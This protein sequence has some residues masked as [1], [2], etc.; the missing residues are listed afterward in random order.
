MHIPTYH[1]D[2][3]TNKIFSGNPAAV[4]MLGEWA[5]KCIVKLIITA[6][7]LMLKPPYLKKT[8]FIYE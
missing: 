8:L 1:I 4:C 7:I 6:F 5:V 3:F 2:A